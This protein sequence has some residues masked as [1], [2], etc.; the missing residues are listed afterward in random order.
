M[1]KVHS[2]LHSLPVATLVSESIED[3][4]VDSESG[5]YTLKSGGEIKRLAGGKL[6]DAS[7]G[8]KNDGL[9]F[10]NLAKEKEWICCSGTNGGDENHYLLF[11]DKLSKRCSLVTMEQSGSSHCLR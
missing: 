10:V 8:L 6:I 3:F 11:D 9:I 7:Q 4:S 2:S 5:V 1:G